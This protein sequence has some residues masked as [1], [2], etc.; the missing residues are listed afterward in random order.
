[1]KNEIGFIL[2]PDFF[3][4]DHP[5]DYNVSSPDPHF[6]WCEKDATRISWE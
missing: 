1:M 5:G 2:H 6:D 4:L 3:V